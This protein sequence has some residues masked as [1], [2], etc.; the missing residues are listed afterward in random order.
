MPVDG[1]SIPWG[2]LEGKDELHL[3]EEMIQF[4]GPEIALDVTRK[5]LKRADIRDVAEQLKD[6]LKGEHG[7]EGCRGPRSSIGSAG[8]EP[9]PRAA[10]PPASAEKSQSAPGPR[11][12]HAQI[13]EPQGLDPGRS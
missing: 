8:A 6:K 9:G 4:Y 3:V 10:I 11:A 12:L 7:T 1:R 5:T 2:R 13:Q